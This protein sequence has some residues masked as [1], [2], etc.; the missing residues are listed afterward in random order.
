MSNEVERRRKVV[1]TGMGLVTPFGIGVKPYWQSVCE[2]K[3]GVSLLTHFNPKGLPCRF[4]GYL[5]NGDPTM[6]FPL[7]GEC[8]TEP[9]FARFAL[10]ASQMASNV[11]GWMGSVD[12]ECAGV[13]IGTSGER[14][15]LAHLAKV[16]YEARREND[17]IDLRDVVWAWGTSMSGA[18]QQL[19]PQYA[20]VLI[21]RSSGI[22]GPVTTFNT[23]C[24]S[25]A[26]AIGAAMRAIQR[27]TVDLAVAGGSECLVSQIGFHIFSPLG[28]LSHRNEAPEKASRPFDAGRDGFV[29]GEGAGIL[30]LEEME[31]AL[32]RGGTIIAEL[33]GYGTS[34]DAYRITDEAPD[35]RGAIGAMQKALGDAS[36]S[37]ND[38]DYINA[39]GTS[40]SM[41]DRVETKAIKSVFGG[42]A[43]EIPV[44]STKSMIGHTISA[45]GAIELITCVLVLKNQIIPPTINYESPDPDCDLDYVPNHARQASVNAAMSNSFGFGGHNDCLVVKTFH[46]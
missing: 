29:L 2:G 46:P 34:C 42:H 31:S 27:G 20:A 14:S 23:A 6:D 4:G 11:S 38:I 24:T 37:P 16:V 30:I 35:G 28:V 45:A 17:E 40:T 25:S 3:S 15:S 43:Y 33:A 8:G 44:S 13:F 1:I 32:Q 10:T 36:V 12:P 18:I 19:L 21:A 41:N 9:R 26:H 7:P 39:H 22:L 5:R